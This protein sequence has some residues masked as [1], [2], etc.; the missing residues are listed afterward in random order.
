MTPLAVQTRYF[1]MMEQ[2]VYKEVSQ[3]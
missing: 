2:L 1:W 3:V